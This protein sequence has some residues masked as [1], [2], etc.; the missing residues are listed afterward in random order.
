MRNGWEGDGETDIE[1]PNSVFIARISSARYRKSVRVIAIKFSA[2]NISRILSAKRFLKINVFG[3]I[4]LFNFEPIVRANP[5]P[6]HEYN[7][8]CTRES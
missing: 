7:P 3:E 4:E 2:E 5:E 8:K 6:I 1:E